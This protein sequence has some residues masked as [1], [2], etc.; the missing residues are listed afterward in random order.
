MVLYLEMKPEKAIFASGCFWGTQYHFD[1]APGVVNT[2]V[3][4]TGGHTENPTYEQ[5][6][7]SDTGHREAIEIEFDP[8]QI[9]YE[10]LVK[11]FFETHDFQQ[12]GGQ[13]PDIGHQ[14]TSAIYYT[15]PEQKETA[16]RLVKELGG[17]GF[18]VTSEVL[19][20]EPFYP[21]EEHHQK[22]YEK[23]DGAPYCHVYI[24]RFD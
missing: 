13:G 5:V 15:T 19:P 14:Y 17:K 23:N 10:E 24:K 7:A 21:A 9:P 12:V 20:S 11:L 18:V 1:K 4:Y 22:Y 6:C 16:E 3:G 2:L 8:E